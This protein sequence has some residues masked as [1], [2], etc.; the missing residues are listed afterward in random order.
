MELILVGDTNGLVQIWDPSNKKA[1][2]KLQ[3]HQSNISKL[4]F[5]EDGTRILTCSVDCTVRIWDEKLVQS[6]EFTAPCAIF[7][8]RI[9]PDDRFV[10]GSGENGIVYIWST[11][12]GVLE[13]EL[14][15]HG[16]IVTSCFWLNER[17]LITGDA[18][19]IMKIWEADSWKCE[20]SIKVY[21]DHISRIIKGPNRQYY[22]SA[23]WDSNI[24]VHGIRHRE[25][26]RLNNKQNTQ[27][28]AI[29]LQMQDEILAAGDWEGFIT[30]W[31]IKSG[32]MLDHWKAHDEGIVGCRVLADG[33]TIITA[34]SEG[35]LKSWDLNE[36]GKKR[37][38]NKHA[39]E[40]TG[41]RSQPKTSK[42]ISASGDGICKVWDPKKGSEIGLVQTRDDRLVSVDIT[43]DD[44]YWIFGSESGEIKFFDHA[45]SDFDIVISAHESLVTTVKVFPDGEPFFNRLDRYQTETLVGGNE[46]CRI[47]DGRALQRNRRLRRIARSAVCD[48]R[49][50]GRNAESLGFYE[51]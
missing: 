5:W 18:S 37:F 42:L 4:F 15:G 41:L 19:G 49:I 36:T 7:D 1:I 3:A 14:I 24:A 6:H 47:N 38:F 17:C 11:K 12:D 39:E 29:E 28:T 40:V 22:I 30:L 2:K 9:S 20:K 27:I 34:D 31:D 50:L 21:E 26:F 44:R 48:F 35:N 25:K 51:N 8:G 33:H 32:K 46:L 13:K 45:Q 10:A 23:S 16:S 43:P